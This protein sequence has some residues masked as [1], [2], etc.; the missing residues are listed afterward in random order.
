M[1]KSIIALAIVTAM[2]ATGAQAAEE[3]VSKGTRVGAGIGFVAGAIGG[4][5]GAAF[6]AIIGAKLGDTVSR[7]GKADR[8]E[9]QVQGLQA[10]LADQRS[11]S[12]ALRRS[13]DDAGRDLASVRRQLQDKLPAESLAEGVE[14]DLFFRTAESTLGEDELAQLKRLA[15]LTRARVDFRLQLDGHADGRGAE[16]FNQALS[17]ARV[18]AVRQA[19]EEQGVSPDRILS[20]AWGESRALAIE[21]DLDGYAMDRRVRVRLLTDGN[22]LSA[23]TAAH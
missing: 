11:R 13:L 3:T 2:L 18:S 7:A 21:G 4:P 23:R 9:G 10:E 14:L 6:G 17:E 5:A 8:L 15:V 12:D 20:G 16:Q 1:R 22:E 19:L